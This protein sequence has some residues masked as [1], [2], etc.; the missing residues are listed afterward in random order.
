[1]SETVRERVWT[2]DIEAPG[3]PPD[4]R[5]DLGAG[6]PSRCRGRLSPSLVRG[7]IPSHPCRRES[8]L[9]DAG[10]YPGSIAEGPEDS[11]IGPP[12]SCYLAD[13]R[14]HSRLRSSEPSQS[15][16]TPRDIGSR[17]HSE[18]VFFFSSSTSVAGG[19]GRG[20]RAKGAGPS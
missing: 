2:E 5:E 15:W 4:G 12:I 20:G 6:W 19:G 18:T 16:E 3:H 9:K 7:Q 8:S 1:M 13:F 10:A 11:G 14:K 17:P